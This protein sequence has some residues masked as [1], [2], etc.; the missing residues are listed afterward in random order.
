MLNEPTRV[1]VPSGGG[2]GEAH[3]SKTGRLENQVHIVATSPPHLAGRSVEGASSTVSGGGK[4]LLV[5]T[6]Q[7]VKQLAAALMQTV[8]A[9]CIVGCVLVKPAAITDVP[10]WGTL[11]ELDTFCCKPEVD[12]V[13]LSLPAVMGPAIAQAAKILTQSGVVWSAIQTLDDQLISSAGQPAVM[14]GGA[15]DVSRLIDRT[16]RPLDDQAIGAA[17]TGRRVMVTG[18]GGSIGSELA[19]R[20]ASYGPSE[21]TLVERSENALF[22]IDGRLRDQY[23]DLTRHTVLH[24]ITHA[25]RTSRL[26]SRVRPQVVF[27][28]AAHKHVPM[29]ED[30]PALAVENNFFGTRSVADAAAAAG[31]ERFVMISTDKAVNPSSVMG[32]TKRLAELYIQHLDRVTDTTFCMVRF[33]NVLGSACSLIPI[34]SKQLASGGPLTVTH[35]D[36]TRYFMTIPEAAG[37]VLQAGAYA[38][39]A[40]VFLLDMGEPVRIVDMAD[41]FLRQHGMAPGVD[42]DIKFTGPRPGEKLFEEL[43]YRGED[44]ATTAHSSIRRWR[45]AVPEAAFVQQVVATFDRMRFDAEERG[46]EL[47]PTAVVAALRAAVPEMITSVAVA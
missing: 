13:L 41:R 26:L 32:A 11:D 20:V 40:E 17:I 4:T 3:A 24:D 12:R 46:G 19:M 35:R 1:T 38:T 2:L 25:D 42:V 31:C 47:N 18:A 45:T 27:H 6:A 34:W 33:G 14:A 43:A 9:P 30:H 29:M 28:A 44:M 15:F 37:L 10:V 21:L 39:G 5:G 22:E 8:P 16:P 7:S 36:M 23:P